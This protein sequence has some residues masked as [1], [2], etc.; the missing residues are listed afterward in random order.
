[1]GE[2]YS[3][4]AQV[5][6]DPKNFKDSFFYGKHFVVEQTSLREH[7]LNIPILKLTRVYRQGEYIYIKKGKQKHR[8]LSD[9][10]YKTGDWV[11]TLT[12]H[13]KTQD[14]K[15]KHEINLLSNLLHGRDFDFKEL[16]RRLEKG[17]FMEFT[18]CYACGTKIDLTVTT[19]GEQIVCY[20]CKGKLNEG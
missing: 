11:Y 6:I 17:I 5:L 19:T 9:K 7:T 20:E 2:P 1:M 14:G 4:I 8:Y 13:E 15:N 16:L 3:G 18:P 10:L 12:H